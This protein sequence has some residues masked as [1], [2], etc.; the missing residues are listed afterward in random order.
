M[1]TT[2]SDLD[3]QFIFLVFNVHDKFSKSTL[4]NKLRKSQ[5]FIYFVKCLVKIIMAMLLTDEQCALRA[6]LARA[7]RFMLRTAYFRLYQ[8]SFSIKLTYDISEPQGILQQAALSKV[9]DLAAMDTFPRCSSCL[10]LRYT[11]TL[12]QT[13]A[14]KTPKNDFRV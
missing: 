13:S 12:M 7:N 1:Y 14:F 3:S 4:T 10:I 11:N 6:T 2:V 9:K 5:T 8:P